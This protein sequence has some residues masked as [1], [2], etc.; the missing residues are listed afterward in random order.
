M[1]EKVPSSSSHSN[2]LADLL[3]NAAREHGSAAAFKFKNDSGVWETSSFDQVLD[4]VRELSLGFVELGVEP[5]DRLSILGNTRPEWTLFDFAAMTAG[6]VVVPIYQTNSPNECE[7]VLEHSGARFIVVEDQEQLEKIQAVRDSLPDLEQIIMMLGEAEGAISMAELKKRGAAVDSS[8]FKDRYEAVTRDDVC[9]IV[10]TSGTTGPPKGCVLSHGNYRATLDMADEADILGAGETT[11]LFLP[12]A[13]VFALLVQYGALDVGGTIAYWERDPLRIVPS[14][15]EVKPENFPSVPRIFEKVHDTIIAGAANAGGIKAAM[16]KWAI[17]VGMRMREV[18]DEG[19]TPG[20]L[21]KKEYEIADRLVL[22]KIRDVFGGR[23]KIALTGAAPIDPEILRFFHAA[24]INLLEAWGMT[25][26]ST[27]GTANLPGA[28]EVGTVGR[29]LPGVDAK[30]SEDGELLVR[31][32]NVFQGYYRNE[33]ATREVLVDGW[34][35]TGD[36]ASIDDDGYV[37]ITGRKK[38]IIIT[39]GGKNITPVNIEA[40][41]KRHPLV[42]H[43]VVIGDRRP[44]LVALITLDQEALSQFAAEQ[45][46]LDEP[47]AMAGNE[48]VQET[49]EKHIEEVNTHFAPVEQVKRFQVLPADL[50]Q[51]GGELTPTMKLK[52]PVITTK[53]AEQIEALYST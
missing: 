30:I 14:L 39:A 32:D 24:G 11:F 40:M 7:Y 27:G 28:Q 43:C 48:E 2:T 41:I 50:T 13:H 49:I 5:G 17:R 37:T 34:L 36:L 33:E 51:E 20:F 29:P 16:F 10:Y 6:A 52:R 4:E 12:L 38:E 31:G 18:E 25:E 44:Y 19:K 42:S 46:T 21:L 53:Y 1:S 45:G 23:L 8:T 15:A 47:A 3:P 22:S 26:T 35:H 9:K